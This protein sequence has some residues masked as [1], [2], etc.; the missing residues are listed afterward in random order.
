MDKFEELRNILRRLPDIYRSG[1]IEGYLDHYATDMTSCFEG[2][3]SDYDAACNFIR[4]LF[5]G[6]GKTL[7]FS[8][9]DRSLIQ[10]SGTADAA[11]IC[12]P[13]RETF[14]FPDGHVTDTEYYQTE[15]WFCRNDQ[16]KIVHVH[17]T[18]I[19]EHAVST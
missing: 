4:S 1:D 15:V 19:K 7:E 10:F 9:G 5:E 13:W 3:I 6:G 2:V 14:R 18:V 8:T 11:T 16:W 12:Y 17:L